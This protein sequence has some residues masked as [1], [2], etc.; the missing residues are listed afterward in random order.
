MQQSPVSFRR[1]WKRRALSLVMALVLALGLV[2]GVPGLESEASAH[3]A[4]TYLSQLVEWGFIRADQAGYPDRALTRADFMAI[5]N[6][7]YGYQ[8]TG[9]TPFEDVAE[10][11]WFYDD[12]GIAYT[13]K[14]IK[15]TSPTTASPRSPLTRET[16][17]TILGR[18]MMLQESAGELLDFT[19][20]R[21][22]SNW[23]RGTVKSSLEHYLVSGYDDGTFRPQR[24]VS[25]GEMAAMVTNLIGTPLQEPGDYSL[26][27]TF[28]NVTITSPGVTLR[29]TVVSGDLYISGG[30]GLGDVVLENVTVLG[31][32]IASGTGSSE[33]G[34]DSILLRNVTADELLVDNLQGN[35]VSVRADGVT[36]IGRTTVRT[37]A[38]I[39]DNTPEGMGLKYI[40]VEGETYPEGEE[41]DDWE[42]IQ[43][44]LAGRIEEVVN[45]T[46]QSTIHVG[47]GTVAKLTVDE[48]ATESFVII[49]RG[50]VVNELNLDTTTEVTGQGDIGKLVVNAPDCVV[51]MLPDQIEIRP[52]LTAEIAGEE[53]DTVAAEESSEEPRILAGYPQAQDVIPNGLDAVFM[54]NKSGTIYWAVSALTDGS[55]G[56]EDLIKP[57][58]YGSK[59]VRTGTLSVA[60]GNEETTAKITGLTPGGSYYLSAVL[61]DARDK[62]STVK[63][64]SFTTPDNTVPAFNNG[65]PKMS[66]VSRTDSVVVVMPNKD[67]K[68]YYA[69]L[70]EGATAPTENELKTSSVAGALGYGVRDVKKNVEDA[71]RVNDVILDETANYVLYLWLVD[72]D[73]V[74]KGKIVPLKFTTDDE[75]PPEFISGPTQVK[76]QATSVGLEYQ[77]S[78]NGTVYWVAVPAGT[79]YPKPE[80][81]TSYERAPLD[82]DY[83]ILQVVSGMNVGADGKYGRVTAKQGVNGTINI[84]GLKP[85]SVY[86]LYYV[87]KDNAGP[88]RNYSVSVLHMTINTEDNK[89]PVFT[90]TFSSTSDGTSP[91]AD[92]SIFLD[93][94]E[95]LLYLG[96]N[97]GKSLLELYQETQTGT[98]A[99]RAEARD[100]LAAN[101]RNSIV[102][103]K[104]DVQT[105]REE[106]IYLKHQTTDTRTD[107]TV[108]YTQVKVESRREG[109]IRLTFPSEGLQLENGGQYC[110]I[111][112]DL[113]DTSNARNP[114][115]PDTGVDFWNYP[116][117][118]AR[119]GH[120]VKPFVVDLPTVNLDVPIIG[121]DG[122][123]FRD[124]TGTSPVIT[125]D[126]VRMDMSFYMEPVS[127]K[128]MGESISYDVL[129][130]SRTTMHYDLY[131]R[132]LDSTSSELKPI[133]T[134]TASGYEYPATAP[135]GDTDYLLHTGA[136]VKGDNTPDKNGW[137]YLG[138]SGLTNPPENGWSGRSVSS[139]F[140]GCDSS[141]FGKLNKL[142]ENLQYQFVVSLTFFDGKEDTDRTGYRSWNDTARLDVNV[143]AGQ[144]QNL[145][146]L[147]GSLTHG[148]WESYLSLGIVRG[149]Q[150]VGRWR[151]D[152]NQV[153]DTQQ[154]SRK[155]SVLTLPNF[156]NN[157]PEFSFNANGDVSISLNLEAAGTVHYA[158]SEVDPR[159]G[160]PLVTTIREVMENTSDYTDNTNTAYAPGVEVISNGATPPQMYV[161]TFSPR[162]PQKGGTSTVYPMLDWMKGGDGATDD[163]EGKNKIVDP[164]NLLVVSKNW[165]DQVVDS[166][167]FTPQE[168]VNDTVTSDKVKPNTTYF[169]YFVITSVDNYDNMSHVYIYQFTT[170]EAMKP[171]VLLDASDGTGNV[172]M[173]IDVATKGAYRVISKSDAQDPER[174]SVLN[175]PFGKYT[176][177]TGN[178]NADGTLNSAAGNFTDGTPENFLV[179]ADGTPFTV[180]DALLTPYSYTTASPSPDRGGDLTKDPS[181]PKFY[182]PDRG[183]DAFAYAEGYTVFDM[184]ASDSGRDQ[185]YNFILNGTRLPPE[186]VNIDNWGP[187]GRTDTKAPGR[188]ETRAETLLEIG[189][190]LR[191][192]QYLFLTYAINPKMVQ[193][194]SNPNSSQNTSLIASFSGV[195]FQKG[196]MLPPE[197]DGASGSITKD[198]AGDTYS[199]RVRI[200]FDNDTYLRG[201]SKAV[202]ITK[203]NLLT[204]DGV[205]L[206]RHGSVAVYGTPSQSAFTLVFNSV[207]I[208][209]SLVFPDRYFANLNNEEAKKELDISVT[210]ENDTVYLVVTWPG[211][212]DSP[213]KIPLSEA[214][215][216]HTLRLTDTTKLLQGSQ[217]ALTL[218]LTAVAGGTPGSDAVK[219]EM[220]PNDLSN[221]LFTWVVPTGSSELTTAV[222]GTGSE[223]CT[224]TAAKPGKTTVTVN[225]IGTDNAGTMQSASNMITVTVL[226]QVT[227]LTV[228]P[229][230][231]ATVTDV[232]KLTMPIGGTQNPSATVTAAVTGGAL[233]GT[234]SLACEVTGT[235]RQYVNCDVNG[236]RITVSPTRN[237]PTSGTAEVTVKLTASDGT[238]LT[239]D[240]AD[241]KTFTVT[242][243]DGKPTTPTP[244]PPRQTPAARPTLSLDPIVATIAVGKSATATATVT[245][246][247]TAVKWS[248]SNEK[249]ATVVNGKITGVGIGTTTISGTVTSGKY[250]VSRNVTVRVTGSVTGL[251]ESSSKNAAWKASSKT[252]TLTKAPNVSPSAVF[253]VKT[254][255]A[256][257]ATAAVRCSVVDSSGKDASKYI[258]CTVGT[259][260]AVTIRPGSAAE[261]N[262]TFTVT[263]DLVTREDGVSLTSKGGAYTFT[264]QVK[265]SDSGLNVA[266]RKT[267]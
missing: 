223:D 154:L 52:G 190:D 127:T 248:S 206:F 63:V 184:Y 240:A 31:R 114:I 15:G 36:E 153:S 163:P 160:R 140:N 57:P 116:T 178:V 219:A 213:W 96:Q 94:T 88:D 97:G 46:P 161:S 5:T 24:N 237:A 122:P 193:A 82:S 112:N 132:V 14:Y 181:Y 64:I 56:E 109:G 246:A 177:H 165:R 78:E 186:V 162:P 257:T 220:D 18:N 167:A 173:S 13:A 106:N 8:E 105:K 130:W 115:E 84:S 121:S 55:I 17:A 185:L 183:G 139:F 204:G 67:C 125:N 69:L 203:D 22:I 212:K 263:V 44:S 3:W 113:A 243:S 242:F 117:E 95:D 258:S 155:F 58:S 79:V 59:A 234:A 158:I 81:G 170:P 135:S 28:G 238:D 80:P 10:N 151:N 43:V 136:S 142:S 228:T 262:S 103:H 73:G 251:T 150:S 9:E 156:I 26:G 20:A 66:K 157:A 146:H 171:S 166:G 110:F 2:P 182:Y 261:K 138:N 111:I 208:G 87:A 254:S 76:T 253:A 51:E 187:T 259:N 179:N 74:N 75:T 71:F 131:Y 207:H 108:D 6:R 217:S 77:L 229:E 191:D 68:L 21:Q 60:K 159:T 38:Y 33:G 61:V 40:S 85:E 245:P 260:G 176:G 169:A 119:A 265:G 45:R 168:G 200:H 189:E 104:Y 249:V 4:D 72:A 83:A 232:T 144:A 30:V 70:P 226:G 32:I 164:S 210:K 255:G 47:R 250:T 192:S 25:W 54:T 195:M 29:D 222:S 90:Q 123:L 50:A 233:S 42:P 49:D 126:P 129:L 215:G 118:S 202:T 194:D 7:A 62:R 19:D 218:E 98:E 65:Y 12:V 148:E 91:R 247:G 198:S 39:E 211:A 225:G 35:N 100:R 197:V 221:P 236:L 11:D 267:S 230:G 16:A 99:S 23:A 201:P 196:K 41:P 93:V 216:D 264:V 124:T 92:T 102:L 152:Q 149:A 252:L 256:M 241:K 120:D 227:G 53:M 231:N 141:N 89:P 174:V 37:N 134:A 180:L 86:D 34:E 137:I 27:G 239:P 172:T 266:S 147:A 205:E 1:A 175:Q 209:D 235:A 188:N 199:G 214:G 143:A 133:H 244:A 224:I 128:S 107:W 48:A 145:D 101:L